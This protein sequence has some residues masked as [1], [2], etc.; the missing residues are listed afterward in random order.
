MIVHL[1]TGVGW[2]LVGLGLLPL[3]RYIVYLTMVLER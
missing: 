3:Q 1:R 2:N